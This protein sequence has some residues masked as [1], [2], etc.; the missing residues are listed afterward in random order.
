MT[1]QSQPVVVKNETVEENP[2]A[3]KRETVEIANSNSNSIEL[4]Q[5]DFRLLCALERKYLNDSFSVTR[6][7][8]QLLLVLWDRFEDST[9]YGVKE[10]AWMRNSFDRLEILSGSSSIGER[11][12]FNSLKR[13]ARQPRFNSC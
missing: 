2:V 13:Q 4:S 11:I 6:F 9:S 1:S 7:E 3:V 12:R 10:P 8:H 5:G